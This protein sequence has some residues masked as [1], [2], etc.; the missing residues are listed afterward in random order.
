MSSLTFTPDSREITF[1][2][3]N[4]DENIAS[5]IVY[6]KSIDIE[7][8]VIRDMATG[9]SSRWDVTGR[10]LA[11]T[12]FDYR[13]K[14]EGLE[15]ENHGLLM[16]LDTQSGESWVVDDNPDM[17]HDSYVFTPD[18]EYILLDW[19]VGDCHRQPCQH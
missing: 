4:Y 2:I 10:Y 12:N 9:Y 3:D 8:G 7:T 16:V 1:R 17:F 6:I 19:Q 13:A 15:P 14:V 18:G 11:Y 5:S